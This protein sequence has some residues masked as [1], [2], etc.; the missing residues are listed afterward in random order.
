M[1][2]PVIA[3][4]E[5]WRKTRDAK[6]RDPN[7]WLTLVGL[8]WLKQGS[9]TIGS[10]EDNSIRFAPSCPAHLGTVTLNNE[11]LCFVP[12][13]DTTVT[14]DG[15]PVVS[16]LTLKTDSFGED[17]ATT[18]KCKTLS[19]F[20]VKRGKRFGL[21]VK[22]SES[23]VLKNFH[24]LENFPVNLSYRI[25]GKFI[26]HKDG[27]KTIKVLNAIQEYEDEESL[28]HVEFAIG[29]K[30]H[31]LLVS[32]PIT[33]KACMLVFS[34]GTSGDESYGGGRFLWI[35][36]P[37]SEGTVTIDFNKAYNPPCVFTPW[38][39]CPLP[40]QENRLSVRIEAGEKTF[41]DH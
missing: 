22:D 10:A 39:T 33:T 18:L 1:S 23:E 35:D 9:N 32:G 15:S 25:K 2:E 11:E 20:V 17:K 30:A 13:P 37:N 14:F 12:H 7:G 40:V 41:G 29:G 19:W 26:P 6:C 24:G 27:P 3:E 34:D 28:G 16:P 38:A 4:I 31:T 5:Q 21:R 8:H 36:P